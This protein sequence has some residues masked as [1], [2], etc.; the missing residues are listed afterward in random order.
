M[1]TLKELLDKAT[2]LP[3][4]AIEGDTLNPNRTWGVSRYLTIEQNREV[5]GDDAEP[6]TRTEVI[7]EVCCGPTDEADA[8]LMAHAINTLPKLVGALKRAFD[9]A[10]AENK[11][12]ELIDYLDSVLTEANN[13]NTES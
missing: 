9:E 6:N 5:D 8:R 13:I 4:N 7:A 10:C 11:N 1:K 3:W 12:Q 2:P